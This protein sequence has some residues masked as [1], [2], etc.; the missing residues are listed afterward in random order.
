MSLADPQTL[1]EAAAAIRAGKISSVEMT[2]DALARAT[3]AQPRLNAFIE[4]EAEAA[5]DAAKA[6]DAQLAAGGTVGPLHGVPLAHKDM[7]DREGRVTG[8]GS[9]IR[10][11]HIATETSTVMQR[12]EAAGAL[13]IG[14]L[15]M[16]EFAMGPTGH[17]FHHGRAINPIDPDRITGGSSSGSGAAVGGGVV[18][19]ALGSDTGGSIRLPAACC[20][21]AG[22]KPTQGR[23][24]RH[25]VMPLSFSQD[26]VGPLARTVGDAYRMLQLIAGPDGKDTT[27]RE[28]PLGAITDDIAALRIGIGAGPFAEG[29]STEV[30]AAMSEAIKAFEPAT[31]RVAAIDMPDFDAVA[32]LANVVAMAEAGAAHFDWLRDRAGDYGPQVGMRLAQALAMPAP[33]YIRALQIRAVML[34]QFLDL[35]FADCD[36]LVVPAMP[37]LPPLAADVDVGAGAKMNT[38]ISDMTK[39]TRPF[40]YLGLPVV[41]LPGGRSQDGLPVGLQ[42]VAAPWRE[43][44][45]ASVAIHLERVLALGPF[46]AH[47]ST[48][49]AA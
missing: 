4:I 43:D 21:I 49:S 33:I 39:F 15:N 28:T 29:L 25:G 9:K 38:V 13:S 44:L 42:I 22:I 30:A 45:A 2:A 32:E 47:Q 35:V 5:L 31:A 11:G 46:L 48:R 26:C 19:A 16:S 24:S 1:S 18:L 10:A 20:G 36:V 27:C 17:N 14:R 23:V 41:T 37:F 7:Y 3:H 12:L 40:S 34:R 8:C 6:A